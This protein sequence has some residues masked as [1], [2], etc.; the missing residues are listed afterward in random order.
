MRKMRVSIAAAI[1]AAALALGG[2]GKD[3][4]A[5]RA[6]PS[7]QPELSASAVA[8]AQAAA[9][10]E[11]KISL[12][13][14][15][16][17]VWNPSSRS[18]LVTINYANNQEQ[19]IID[20]LFV[21]VTVGDIDTE[22]ETINLTATNATGERRIMTI[23]RIWN[24]DKT[25]FNL[26]ITLWDGSTDTLSFVRRVQTDDLNRIAQLSAAMARASAK[27]PA[28]LAAAAE[29][30]Q[31]P[32]S[33]APQQP[34]LSQAPAAA[35]A[36]ASEQTYETSFD[37][38]KGRALTEYLIC[39]DRELAASDK[40]LGALFQQAKAAATDK[41]AFAER[42]RKQWNYR[43]KNCR[44]K[45]CLTAWYVYQKGELTKIAQTGEVYATK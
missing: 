5:P 19:L 13:Q 35:N 28:D 6:L 7:S 22:N 29:S 38:S 4:E 31:P 10:N 32:V 40:E 42:A 30:A 34:V 3:A 25:A 12:L 11:K 43:E 39:H 17:G 8:A 27:K 2:C 23:R 15:T 9:A 1:G 33:E 37:C 16:S 45:Q 20:D 41:T 44:D 14:A 24:P 18:G 26:Q 36:V 21:P